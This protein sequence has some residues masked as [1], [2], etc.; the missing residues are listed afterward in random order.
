MMLKIGDKVVM[1]D[2]YR[3]AE[4]NKGVVFTV[5]SSPWNC[6]GTEVVLLDNYSGG[7]AVDGLSLAKENK[8]TPQEAIE[9]LRTSIHISG[10]GDE[11]CKELE[12]RQI[13]VSALKKKIAKK[14]KEEANEIDNQIDFLCPDCGFYLADITHI[15]YCTR[16]GRAID[17][18]D[19]ND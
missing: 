11:V 2:K 17:W 3:V 7:Y 13:A 14:P 6:G 18:S 19:I 9:I 5:K 4:K 8:M 15:N 16:C 12:A 1:N 10:K